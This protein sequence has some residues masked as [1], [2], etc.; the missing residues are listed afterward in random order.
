MCNISELDTIHNICL[1]ELNHKEKKI[2][3]KNMKNIS[4]NF[5]TIL[6]TIFDFLKRFVSQKK[7]KMKLPILVLPEQN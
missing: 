6:Q 1:R 2:I 7:S 3:E 5:R 4:E